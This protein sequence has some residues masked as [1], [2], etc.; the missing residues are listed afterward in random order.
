MNMVPFPRLH[1][2]M[3]G[4]APLTSRGSQQ[5]RALTVPELTQQMF[6][7]KNMMAA[8]DPRHGRYLTVAAMFRGRMSMKEVD[9]QMLNVQNKNSSYF[10]EWIPNNVKTAV[11]DIPPRGLKMSAT[12]VGNSTAIQ[13]LFKRISEQ[14]T[15]MFRRKAFLHWYTGE[16]MDEMEFTEVRTADAMQLFS[17]VLTATW[18]TVKLRTDSCHVPTA[19]LHS[20]LPSLD[21]TY[22]RQVPKKV[23]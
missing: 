6:D 7:A 10:V 11:C 21:Y 14:F 9:E 22:L 5:Y 20:L 18:L 19:E 15:A 8:C 23:Y 12:F 16:G 1:F 17:M 4:F 3:P 13:E 2:F